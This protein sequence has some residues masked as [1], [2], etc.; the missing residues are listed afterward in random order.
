MKHLY[1]FFFLLLLVSR[2]VGQ[3]IIRVFNAKTGLP[4]EGVLLVSE[5]FSTQTDENGQA[6]LRGFSPT[7]SIFFKHSSYL[8]LTSTALKIEQQG[9]QVYLEENP[10]KLDE[11]V[12]SVNRWQ[13]SRAEIP[14]TVRTIQPEEIL[15]S[16][17]QTTA[18]LLGTQS[19]VFIQKSQMGGGSPMIRGFSANRLLIVVDGI[20]MNNAIY[21]SGNLQNVISVDAQSLENAEVIFGPGSSI[22]GSDALGGV[23]SFNTLSPKLSTSAGRTKSFGTIYSRYSS[24][25][26][27]KNGH[28]SFNLGGEKWAVAG[29]FTFSDFDDLRMGSSGPDSYLRTEYVLNKTFTGS[30]VIIQNENSKVQKYTGYQQLNLLGKIRFR[31]NAHF[32]LILSAQ[33]AQSSDIPRY[34]RLI[35]YSDG[36]LKYADWHYGPQKWSLYSMRAEYE[37]SN[38]FFD[39]INL[40]GGYQNYGESRITRNLNEAWRNRREEQLDIFSMNLDFG[41]TFNPKSEL[42]YGFENFWNTVYSSGISTNLLSNEQE[43]ISSRYPDDSKYRSMAAYYSLKYKITPALILQ[44]GSRFTHTHLNGTF[45]TSFYAF[46]YDGF[47]MDNSAFTGNLGVVWHPNPNWQINLHGS[48]G[49]RAPN[50]DDVAKVFDSEPGNVV[51]PNPDL[52]PEYARNIEGS[53]IHRHKDLVKVEA[54]VFYTRLKDAMVRRAYDGLGQDSILYDGELSQVEALVNAESAT[55]YGVTLQFEYILGR[56][57]LTRH[58]VS[59]TNGEDPDGLPIRHVPPTFGSSHFIFENPKWHIDCSLNYNGK[60]GYNDLAPEEQAKTHLY[61]T[62][63]NGN[64][65]SPSWWTLNFT[66]Q[67]ALSHKVSLGA[68]VEN[69]LDKR[70]RPY[71]SGLVSPGINIVISACLKI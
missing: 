61:A 5:Q 47:D 3:E 40:L 62:D 68:G 9:G 34:D 15:Q 28:A 27:E 25:N 66:S 11:I 13:Q 19:G 12:V 65:Y 1:L 36:Q 2:G 39:K 59:F 7:A 46:P 64:P 17:P 10:I 23:M 18:D 44:V 4:I 35:Q 20:R 29:S 60:M 31:P 58:S 6:S 30:D 38:A 50:I 56:H 49:F 67:Y 70:Y 43:G 41:K 55:I 32:D 16:A 54:T 24:A 57:W 8:N 14:H 26:F 37:H 52:K 53:I 48:T 69:L 21:R 45:D 42:F 51:V 33:H 63:K 22:Y 71:S